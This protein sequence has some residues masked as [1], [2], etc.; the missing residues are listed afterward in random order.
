ML[1]K[2]PKINLDHS[3]L[4]VKEIMKECSTIFL[5]HFVSKNERG[6]AKPFWA[7]RHARKVPK[8]S[9]DHCLLDAKGIMQNISTVF[10]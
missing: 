6:P 4:D 1:D 8:I 9:L 7:E 3:L 5:Y 2:I 10:L